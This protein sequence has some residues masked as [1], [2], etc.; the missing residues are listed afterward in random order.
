MITNLEVEESV[1]FIAQRTRIKAKIAII[2]GSG[3]GSFAD[4]LE[5]K[6][7]IPTGKIPHYPQSTVKGHEGYL[8][9]GTHNGQQMI[10]VQGRTHY[11][12]GYSSEKVTY[13][14]RLLKALGV[15]ILIVT[16]AAGGLNAMFRPGDLMLITDQINFM[17]SNPLKGPEK[18]GPPRFPD[19][20]DPYSGRYWPLVE[21]VAQNAKIPLKKG[22][23]F[24]ST[25]PS[26]ETAAEVRMAAKLGADAASM[27]T[28]PEGIVANHAGLDLIGISCITNMATGINPQPLSHDEVTQ[29]AEKVK[30]QFIKLV[31]GIIE[32]LTQS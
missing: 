7:K 9:F 23:L 17:F 4:D 29:T 22:V 10:A 16:N 30:H 24:A 5:N 31:S 15:E 25:G 20:S 28:V 19:M 32:A 11:Y 27:S 14:V 13:V 1:N 6:T 21:K 18:F 8:V 12:E 3:L 2:L 26:Y